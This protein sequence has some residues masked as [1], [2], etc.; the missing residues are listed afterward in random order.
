MTST[1]VKILKIHDDYIKLVYLFNKLLKKLVKCNHVSPINSEKFIINEVN[2]LNDFQLS[3]F[4]ADSAN[5]KPKIIRISIFSLDLN[6]I[7]QI[8]VFYMNDQPQLALDSNNKLFRPKSNE[9]DTIPKPR[10][11]VPSSCKNLEKILRV[12]CEIVKLQIL[13]IY[14]ILVVLISTLKPNDIID[15]R[16]AIIDELNSDIKEL[17][18]INFIKLADKLSRFKNKIIKKLNNIK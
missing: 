4:D 17:R 13:Y 10:T 11:R 6:L 8:L 3:I 9:I 2:I 16:D 15:I 12:V 5:I 14:D 7:E 18:N 1:D